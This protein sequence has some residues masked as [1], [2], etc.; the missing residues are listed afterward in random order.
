MSNLNK[1]NLNFHCFG[2]DN[3]FCGFY[4][5]LWFSCLIDPTGLIGLKLFFVF[6][7]IV[8]SVV[9]AF[10]SFEKLFNKSLI[11]NIIYFLFV[12]IAPLYGVLVYALRGV[13]GDFIDKSYISSGFYLIATY[14]A[15]YINNESCVVKSA[16]L[17][18]RLLSYFVI[19]C[20]ISFI[21]NSDFWFFQFL[22]DKEV[23]YLG[24]R[25]YFGLDFLYIYFVSSPLLILLYFF[26]L[27]KFI[28]FFTLSRF[29]LLLV[30]G[31]AL[32]LT[33]TRANII[34]A[35]I[36][37][38]FFFF[39][40]LKV[41]YKLFI[42]LIFVFLCAILFSPIIGLVS[43]FFDVN[44]SSN[45]VKL[46]YLKYYVDI[47]SDPINLIFGQG[48]NAH[49]WSNELRMM[50]A[51][52][53]EGSVKTELTYFEIYRVFGVFL[54]GLLNFSILYL[55]FKLRK[56]EKDRWI[57]WAAFVYFLGAAVNPYIFSSNGFM[58]IS[59]ILL[60]IFKNDKNRSNFSRN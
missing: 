33:G 59:L 13:S 35:C 28:S 25:N 32:F 49:G 41:N 2:I 6:F 51:E 34:I 58:F 31:G 36:T 48:F 26:D 53:I 60:V 37:P 46:G 11:V 50:L 22:L 47:F 8:I 29:L 14:F 57:F 21:Y 54:G 43:S 27:Y 3:I 40:H 42:F 55:I 23:L 9:V 44:E 18:M 10:F 30:S 4:F 5:L 7:G 56:N 52:N 16:I 19:F 38:L 12:I 15:F 20:A 39:Y 17:A 1:N 45:G 24:R